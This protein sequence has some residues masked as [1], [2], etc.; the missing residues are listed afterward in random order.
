MFK[1]AIRLTLLVVAASI[2]VAFLP[3]CFK[4][5]REPVVE[6]SQ[7]QPIADAH[8]LLME[9]YAGSLDGQTLLES[10]WQAVSTYSLLAPDEIM[11]LRPRF[12]SKETSDR[13]A[14]VAAVD[15]L[16][17]SDSRIT[18]QLAVPAAL[19]AMTSQT[20]DRTTYAGYA[21]FETSDLGMS[22]MWK[23]GFGLGL[24]YELRPAGPADRVGVVQG[25]AAASFLNV[26]DIPPA[27]GGIVFRTSIGSG[28]QPNLEA[29]FLTDNHGRNYR[30]P[31][32]SPEKTSPP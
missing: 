25:D 4:S 19:S 15:T 22:V 32:V 26:L 1:S 28:R 16:S 30:Q 7:F 12:T 2:V 8:R 5:S 11:R 24:I 29:G 10:A 31:T 6:T 23:P 27:V 9:N 17:K 13:E 21:P 14:L 3:G 20:R 18:P